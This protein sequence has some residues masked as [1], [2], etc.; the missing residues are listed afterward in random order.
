MSLVEILSNYKV[1]HCTSIELKEHKYSIFLN[2]ISEN[3][4]V[5]C[6]KG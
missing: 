4:G 3:E 6:D 5:S 2:V 1:I